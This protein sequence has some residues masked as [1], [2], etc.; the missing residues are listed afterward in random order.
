M[1]CILARRSQ[2]F[3]VNYYACPSVSHYN[4]QLLI[5]RQSIDILCARYESMLMPNAA[6]T[7]PDVLA[8]TCSLNAEK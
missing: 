8:E 7:H 6:K 5:N 3:H 4:H 2:S 1:S